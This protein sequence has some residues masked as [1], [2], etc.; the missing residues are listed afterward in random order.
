[1]A[2]VDRGLLSV[3]PLNVITMNIWG[4]QGAIFLLGERNGSRENAGEGGPC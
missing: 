1:M 4:H 2:R 3:L